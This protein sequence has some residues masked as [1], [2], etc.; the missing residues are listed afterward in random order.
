MISN[1]AHTYTESGM[2]MLS[3]FKSLYRNFSFLSSPLGHFSQT[4]ER[5]PL[6]VFFL[7]VVYIWN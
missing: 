6:P 2:S 4:P 5:S 1:Y 7:F 3:V